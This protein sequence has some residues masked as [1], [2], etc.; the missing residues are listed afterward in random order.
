MKL[1]RYTDTACYDYMVLSDDGDWVP[2]SEALELQE[3]LAKAEAQ[4][5]RLQAIYD[6]W[7]TAG[8][9]K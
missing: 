4:R 9:P 3:R 7:V 6:A 8:R 1:T 2:A 5:D